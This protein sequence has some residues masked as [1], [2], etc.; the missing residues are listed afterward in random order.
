M[1]IEPFIADFV[2]SGGRLLLVGDPSRFMIVEDEENFFS[3]EIASDELPPYKR[4]VAGMASC[5]TRLEVR[6]PW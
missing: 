3:F 1:I 2:S 4:R 5:S 6:I